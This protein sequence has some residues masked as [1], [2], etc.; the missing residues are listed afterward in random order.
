MT[1]LCG[2][3]SGH[4]FIPY[5]YTCGPEPGCPSCP[6]GQSCISH[7]CVSNDITCPSTGIVGDNLT[8][9]TTQN[10]QACGPQDNCTATVTLPD[11]RQL[12]A[13][14]DENGNVLLPLTLPGNYTIT[15]L[16]NGQAV[17]VLRVSQDSVVSKPDP[18][19]TVDFRVEMGRDLLENPNRLP[20]L[21]GEI[22]I[23]V[24]PPR[25]WM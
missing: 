18:N 12:G 13:N 15:L 24:G 14:P 21:A 5:N 1:G 9:R 8:C 20:D 7:Q 11:G 17:K 16:K 22:G 19:R 2:Y 4:A 23:R 3:A 25:E 6:L 10:G